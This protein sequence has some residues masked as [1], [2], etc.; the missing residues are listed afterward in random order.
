MA[1]AHK[2][3]V[4]G[5]HLLLEGTCY[6]EAP[7]DRLQDKQEAR[8]QKRVLKALEGPGYRVTLERMA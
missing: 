3:R 5:Y 7:Y 1:V 8:R 4:I 6:E 2:I